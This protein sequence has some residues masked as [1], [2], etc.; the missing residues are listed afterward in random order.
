MDP[1]QISRMVWRWPCYARLGQC[2][3]RRGNCL[4]GVWK[5]HEAIFS[6]SLTASLR[7]T[8]LLA[9]VAQAIH[10]RQPMSAAAKELA[11]VQAAGCRLLTW[12]EL[13]TT[14]VSAR[15]KSTILH[16]PAVCLRERRPSRAAPY[17]DCGYATSHPV[18]ESNGRETQ[19]GSGRPG[20]GGLE[21]AGA[22]HRCPRA[23]RGIEIAQWSHHRGT[24]LWDWT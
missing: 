11:Q 10:S 9:A 1:D 14:C 7:A 4:A 12:D 18:R 22:R 23:Y 16:S 15:A 2:C 21:R 8:G 5:L 13:L 19:Q 20:L 17:C 3:D 24:R 6:A